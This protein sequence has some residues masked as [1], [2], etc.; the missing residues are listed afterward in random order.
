MTEFQILAGLPEA[1]PNVENIGWGNYPHEGFVVEFKPQ[2]TG[3][4][5]GNFSPGGNQFNRVVEHPDGVHVIVITGGDGYIV[6]PDTRMI[7]DRFGGDIQT[8]LPIPEL[9]KVVFGN[10]WRFYSISEKGPIWKTRNV[11]IDGIHDLKLNGFLL[12]GFG[13]DEGNNLIP[14]SVN[15]ANAEVIG[16]VTWR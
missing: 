8:I 7:T 2:D 3:A 1:G 4:W 16:G 15:L 13:E 9:K 5:V 11:S 12:S 6:D 10:W 14:F